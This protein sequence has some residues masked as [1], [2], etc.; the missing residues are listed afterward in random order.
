MTKRKR[1]RGHL[2]ELI[3]TGHPDK[4]DECW[5]WPG[6]RNSKGYGLIWF[7]GR[8]QLAHRVAYEL[9]IGPIPD[10]LMLDHICHERACFNP[11]HLQPV[12]NSQNM[13][14]RAGLNVNNASGHRGVSWHKRESG[15]RVQVWRDGINHYGGLFRSIDDAVAAAE[16]LRKELGV[17]DTASSRKGYDHL[18]QYELF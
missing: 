15:W 2:Q 4:S 9:H 3:R 7:D 1:P 16:R 8:M 5:P 12:T 17:R 10:G 18:T 14:N 13:Q 6:A 11:R